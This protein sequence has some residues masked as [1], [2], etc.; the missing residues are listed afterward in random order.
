VLSDK[1]GSWLACLP[2]EI[3]VDE[4]RRTILA[5]CRLVCSRY[6]PLLGPNAERLP[7]VLAA[8]ARALKVPGVA[9]PQLHAHVGDAMGYLRK[10]LSLL[11]QQALQVIAEHERAILPGA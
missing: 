4:A 7:Q 1:W 11:T 10:E 3:N 8:L 5:L 6:V 9:T 2:L